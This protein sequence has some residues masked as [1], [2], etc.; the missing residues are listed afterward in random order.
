MF[1]LKPFDELYRKYDVDLI[2]NGHEHFYERLRPVD[3]RL[4]VVDVFRNSTKRH[5]VQVIVGCSGNKETKDP[6]EKSKYS[7]ISSVR[8]F[9]V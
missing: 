8:K 4:V 3:A 9:S 6:H 1:I 7:S 2:I 5:P